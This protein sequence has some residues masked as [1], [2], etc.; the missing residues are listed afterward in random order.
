MRAES[1]IQ[2]HSS[3]D[4]FESVVSRRRNLSISVEDT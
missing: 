1:V 3:Y 2:L 4:A